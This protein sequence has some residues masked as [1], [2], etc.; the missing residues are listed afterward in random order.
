MTFFT[1]DIRDR[2]PKLYETDGDDDPPV[3][4]KLYHPL[5]NW[6]WYVIEHDGDDTCFGLVD[7]YE[8][9]LGYFSLAELTTPVFGCQAG[10]DT[11]FQPSTL[12]ALA[13]PTPD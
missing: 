1:D 8:K 4:A 6:N 10:L 2:I 9:E 7:G 12:S 5:L 13:C 11:A 3:W